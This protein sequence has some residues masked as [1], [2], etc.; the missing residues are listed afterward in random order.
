MQVSAFRCLA[1]LCV[2]TAKQCGMTRLGVCTWNP[3]GSRVA[4]PLPSAIYPRSV[5][6]GFFVSGHDLHAGTYAM[7][8]SNVT[9]GKL[10][11]NKQTCIRPYSAVDFETGPA[12]G[13]PDLSSNGEY[14]LGADSAPVQFGASVEIQPAGTIKGDIDL[15]RLEI[16][17]TQAM[18]TFRGLDMTL[19]VSSRFLKRIW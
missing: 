15:V 13:W 18:K 17:D 7:S 11:C 5:A 19:V 2:R 3:L 6:N 16:A 8:S 4:K 1:R 10:L 9:I 14:L 12:I